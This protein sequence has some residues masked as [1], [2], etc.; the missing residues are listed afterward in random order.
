L[1]ITNMSKHAL[2]TA[3]L[4][5]FLVFPFSLPLSAQEISIEH[6]SSNLV[7]EYYRFDASIKYDLDAEVI[8]ALEHGVSLNFDIIVRLVRKRNWSWDP[9]V[10]EETLSFRLEYHPLSDNYVVTN[11]DSGKRQQYRHL[12]EALKSIG[13]IKAH[14]LINRGILD[15]DSAYYGYI[16]ARLT[17]EALPPALRPVIYG[18]RTVKSPWHNWMIK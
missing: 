2:Q 16:R 13:T 15:A 5:V 14:P 10:K 18:S 4:F 9:T 12:S 7:E 17:I 11:L 1:L 8:N 3:A 6:A